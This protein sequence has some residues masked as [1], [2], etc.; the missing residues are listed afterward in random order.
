MFLLLFLLACNRAEAP[1]R[2]NVILISIDTLRSDHLPAYGYR[3]VAT[4]AIDRLAADGIVYEHAFAHVPLTLPSHASIF[5]GL[6][7]AHH[8]VRDNAA[9]RLD[10]KFPT[11][12]SMLR[13]HGYGTGGV[14]SAYV[15]RAATNIGSGFDA[16]DDRIAV[17]EG[18][19]T[20]NLARSGRES[21]AIAK[22]WIAGNATKPFFAFVHLFEPHAPYEPSYDGEIATTDALV[23]DLLDSLRASGLYDDALIILLSDHGEGLRDHGEQEHGVLLYREALQVPLIV[24]L[25]R[26]ERRG[27]RIAE[28]VQL[29]DVLPTIAAVTGATAP[30]H[31]GRSLLDAPQ[32]RVIHGETLYPRLH[33]GWSELHSAIE[34]PHHLINGPKPELY[35][36][37]SDAR[38]TRDIHETERRV[39]AKLQRDI[40]SAASAPAVA[41]RID[42]EEARKLA[43]LGYVSAQSTSATSSTLNP[44]DHL[45][46]LDALKRVTEL[47]AARSFAEAAALME[48]LLATNPGWSDLRDQLGVAYESL[49]DLA[50]AEKTYR[51]AIRV[52][53]ELAPE[54]AL[55]LAHVLV[56]RGALDDAEAHARLALAHDPNATHEMLARIAAAR[57]DFTTARREAKL[58]R[59]D[60]VLAQILLAQNDPG[61]ALAALQRIYSASRANKT[62]LPNGYFA[63]AGEVFLRLGRREE[64]RQAFQQALQL[65]PED[66][67]SRKRLATLE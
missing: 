11:I 35:D 62:S 5:T 54:F 34:W 24:K 40:A 44:R 22:Q 16:Y 63:V 12:A 31:D 6:L 39:Y 21:V 65:H 30:R 7:P 32:R 17:I 48:Q 60:F 2:P 14:I 29:V 13:A 58:A 41:Q 53:P 37:A 26:N 67:A 4:P 23:G 20:G 59:S 66:Q 28:A 15:L 56:E 36:L 42:P 18:A 19:P 38:E 51:D 64:A 8:G 49:G 27:T 55:S 1:A 43:A 50:R 10:A 47:M 61:A 25:P 57:G 33:L 45:Q 3:G 46:D 52:T 9:F